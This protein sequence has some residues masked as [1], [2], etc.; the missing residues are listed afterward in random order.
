[1]NDP[2]DYRGIALLDIFGKIYTSIL[3]R[4]ITFY[5]NIYSKI[6]ESQSDFRESYSTVDNAFVLQSLTDRYISRKCRKLCVAFVNFKQAFDIVNREKLWSV[7]Q[8]VGIKGKLY[9]ALK[10]IYKQV[11]AKVRSNG[12]LSKGFCCATGL[13]QG[14]MLSPVLFTFFINEF[15]ELIENSGTAGVQLFP[16]DIQVLILL[17]ADHIALLSNTIVVLHNS[18]IYSTII[19]YRVNCLL[20][21]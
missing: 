4:R 21:Y 12:G 11:K 9:T 8:K 3:N 18:Y 15:A 10:E 13:K 19:V 6:S 7:L 20:I 17:F 5:V 2:A 14:C 1:M 16:D